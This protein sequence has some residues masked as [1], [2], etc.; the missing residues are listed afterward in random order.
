L[1]LLASKSLSAGHVLKNEVGAL[2]KDFRG[3]SAQICLMLWMWVAESNGGQQLVCR[4]AF[5]GEGNQE[6]DCA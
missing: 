6:P 3:V 1:G 4:A 2:Q 5:K